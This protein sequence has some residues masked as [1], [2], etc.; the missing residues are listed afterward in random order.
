MA[1]LTWFIVL[2][3][4]IA[5]VPGPTNL[6]V[7][8]HA[9]GGKRR[10]VVCVLVGIGLAN[11]LWVS[12]CATGLA[13]LLLASQAAFRALRVVGAAYLSY[14]GI[15]MLLSSPTLLQIE[16]I[17]ARREKG[18]MAQG[19][20]TSATNPGAILFYSALLP[21][22]ASTSGSVGMSAFP[23]G[24]LYICIALLVFSVYAWTVQLLATVLGRHDHLIRKTAGVGLL[25]SGLSLLRWRPVQ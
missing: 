13:A 1:K 20:L 15:R 4:G 8:A 2:A 23:W 9:A 25:V 5:A 16:V 14:L 11:L 22:F 21:Q 12:V 7:M 18:L 19:F 10:S 6:L 24:S 17:D 3:M